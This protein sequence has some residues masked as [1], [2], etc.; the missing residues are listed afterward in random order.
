MSP[1]GYIEKLIQRYGMQDCK[2]LDTPIAKRDKLGLDQ[3]P[4]NTLEIQEMKKVSF[5]QVVRS[6]M[7]AQVCSRPDFSHI[8]GVL[9]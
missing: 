5:A 4:K 9:G 6:L 7:Y 1:K 3:C 8:V 2:P